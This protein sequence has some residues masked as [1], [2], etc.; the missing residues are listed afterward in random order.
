[1][2]AS[3]PRNH[4]R[5]NPSRRHPER[6]HGIIIGRDAPEPVLEA[7]ATQ[8]AG[9]A[10]GGAVAAD[11]DYTPGRWSASGS[12]RAH[13]AGGTVLR[14]PRI[15]QWHRAQESAPSPA[16]SRPAMPADR[17]GTRSTDS[18]PR[19]SQVRVRAATM[20]PTNPDREHVPRWP[21]RYQVTD[22]AAACR[23]R[24]LMVNRGWCR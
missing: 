23:W 17:S 15:L 14:A 16:R 4:S 6:F 24:T 12:Y 9:P 20:M 11:T 1:M 2:A 10:S 22:A 5:I 3:R 18:L 13:A 8:N 21:A 7:A 19:Y